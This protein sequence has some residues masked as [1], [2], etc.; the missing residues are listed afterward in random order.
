MGLQ[1]AQCPLKAG[2]LLLVVVR[3]GE[4]KLI[5]HGLLSGLAAD[6]FTTIGL[7]GQQQ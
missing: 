4:R 1:V 2:Y 5:R 7:S 6:V 3:P